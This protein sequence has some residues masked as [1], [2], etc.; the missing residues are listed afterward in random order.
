MCRRNTLSLPVVRKAPR[1][2]SSTPPH[3]GGLGLSLS[4]T[5]LQCGIKEKMQRTPC[6]AQTVLLLSCRGSEI[7]QG[8]CVVSGSETRPGSAPMLS[9]CFSPVKKSD[10]AE[11]ERAGPGAGP[12]LSGGIRSQSLYLG[13]APCA[14]HVPAA[15]SSSLL[16][17][18]LR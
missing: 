8:L 11:E 9:W 10:R 14:I 15:Q 2:V 13:V 6:C 16:C 18:S 3:T 1:A 5:L 4:K 17:G 7:T 12:S